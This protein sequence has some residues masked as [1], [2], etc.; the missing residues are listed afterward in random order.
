[1]LGTLIFVITEVMFFA[2]LI[3]GY[4]VIRAG[5]GLR[6]VPPADVRLPVEATAINT[7]ALLISGI[8]MVLATRL[9]VGARAKARWAFIGAM[10]LGA[11]FVVLQGQEW[12]KL[13]SAGMT[14]LSGVFAACFFLLIGTHGLHAFSAIIAMAY[15]LIR[16]RKG[17]LRLEHMKAMTV[18][19][20][21]IVLIWPVLYR[22]VYF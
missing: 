5:A 12:L 2:A 21:F 19:W 16:M 22:L 3:S 6:W 7:L 18:Y 20:L 17:D 10:V 15:L 1:V 11:A 9:F 8:L 4:L 14:M 13:I